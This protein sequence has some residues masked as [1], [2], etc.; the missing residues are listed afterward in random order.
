MECAARALL[1]KGPL[2][3]SLKEVREMIEDKGRVEGG[4]QDLGHRGGGPGHKICISLSN[5]HQHWTKRNMEL[6]DGN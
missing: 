6:R 3:K 4:S 2:S 5:C 1:R